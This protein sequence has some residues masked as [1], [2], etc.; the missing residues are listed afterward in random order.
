M[1]EE[2]NKKTF[3]PSLGHFNSEQ[4]HAPHPLCFKII[5]LTFQ[6]HVGE[7]PHW[8][9]EVVPQPQTSPQGGETHSFGQLTQHWPLEGRWIQYCV[10]FVKI[11]KG[12]QN[13]DVHSA[14]WGCVLVLVSRSAIQNCISLDCLMSDWNTRNKRLV[15]CRSYERVDEI[16]RGVFWSIFR[17][18]FL[19][20]THYEATK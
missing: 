1:N 9:G 7:G 20:L 6:T 14:V 8:K 3:C 12:E 15:G 17:Y 11:K 4:F 13:S 10:C 2:V 19:I 5:K 16:S 18:L